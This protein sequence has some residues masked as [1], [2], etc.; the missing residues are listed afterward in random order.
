MKKVK[1]ALITFG[2]IFFSLFFS[3]ELM[4]QKQVDDLKKEQD[5]IKENVS[6]IRDKISGFE[7][8][9]ATAEGDLAKLTKIKLSGYIQAQWQNSEAANIYPNNMFMIRRARVKFTYEPVQGIVF[10][11]QPDFQPGNI[12]VKDAYAVANEPWLKTFSL[13]AGK[14][15][16]P[17]YEVE[18]SSSNREVPER[19]RV[20]RAIYPDER[21]TGAKL[22]IAPPQLPLKIQ[23][24]L[25]NGN[26]GLTITDVNGSNIN[27][28]NNDFDN[29][30]DFMG[31]VTYAF[32]L[33]SVGGLTIGAHGY[34]GAIKANTTDVLNSDYTYNKTLDNIGKL[35]RK[36]WVG[37]EAQLYFDVLGGL[38]L[39][40]EYIFG[41]NGTPGYSSKTSV[42][43]PM[44]SSLKNDTLTLTTLTTNTINN[45]PAI[46]RNFN[47]YYVY[48][49]KNIGKRNQIAIRYDYYDPNSKLASDQ[50]GIAKW[51]AGIAA[52]TDNNYTY[53]GTDPVIATN[54]QTKTVVNN[55]LKSGTSDIKYQTI[56]LAYTYFFD[57]NIKFMLAYEIPMNKKVGVNSTGVGNV[58]STYTKNGEPGIFDY[59]DVIKQNVLTLRM[60]VK[61]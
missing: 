61:F 59:S 51:D 6:T 30:K 10:V 28:V 36:N 57:D 26:D 21:A 2:V 45:R 42:V 43:S 7:E 5:T 33:G 11:I 29:H 20:I 53:A 4:A 31:R 12:T 50:I 41:I 52:K 13:W 22:E 38:A 47:G 39:K 54:T 60:Q 56:T 18:Y 17:N 14:F 49:I 58:T 27:P 25:F 40:G 34:Y 15:N 48:L 23:L 37:F 3:T 19:S 1:N 46:E 32:K 24:A 35:I 8:R 16:R 55:S 44:T 9:L